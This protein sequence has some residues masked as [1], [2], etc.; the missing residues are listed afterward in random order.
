M[1]VE[2]RY[3]PHLEPYCQL[4]SLWRVES[5]SWI[6]TSPGRELINLV[7]LDGGAPLFSL[8]PRAWG[9][10]RWKCVSSHAWPPGPHTGCYAHCQD[11]PQ[12]R[13]QGSGTPWPRNILCLFVVRWCWLRNKVKRDSNFIFTAVRSTLSLSISDIVPSARPNWHWGSGECFQHQPEAFLR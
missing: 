4:P 9:G 7:K 11:R 1:I 6:Q 8:S 10:L 12:P 2:C 5:L 13:S 3:L